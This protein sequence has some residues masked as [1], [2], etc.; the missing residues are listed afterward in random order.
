MKDKLYNLLPVALQN[1]LVSFEG[2]RRKKLRFDNDFSREISKEVLLS[3]TK[4]EQLQHVRVSEYLTKAKKESSFWAKH[5]SNDFLDGFKLEDI[6]KLPITSKQDILA[7]KEGFQSPL[8]D[9]I[10]EVKTSGTSG[11][12]LRFT[13]SNNCV[14]QGFTL[15]W[16]ECY[17]LHNHGDKYGTFNGNVITPLKQN[18]PPYWRYNKAFNQTLF[19]IFHMND[20]TLMSYYKEIKQ[21]PYRFLNGYP[22]SISMFAEF[23]LKN[24]LEPLRIEAIYTSSESLFEWQR[25]KME[26]AFSCKV[27][28]LYSNA[29]QTVFA[30][31]V[32]DGHYKV[33]KLCSYVW[34]KETDIE[35]EG[36][37][38]Y[39]VIGTNYNNH[40]FFFINYDTGD[41]VLLNDEG[42]VKR[43]LG[44]QDDVI[45]LEDGRK[46]GRLDHLFKNSEDVVEA[47]IIQQNYNQLD[48]KVKLRNPSNFESK[49]TIIDEIHKRISKTITVNF[50]IVEA[51]S[52]SPN[53][54]IRFV[55]KN[56]KTN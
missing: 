31:Q 24:D 12:G 40:A 44:R 49:K 22:S 26:K 43:V 25:Q 3:D 11:T 33:S 34:F 8:Q 15:L 18:K 17:F 37:K 46:V 36:E 41:L 42:K 45:E 47:Q 39:K 48:I 29:E 2:K 56:F 52:K 53:G 21:N 9:N 35:I 16:D 7:N 4:Q 10:S 23:I 1:W 51:I 55:V 32:E 28:D 19:S 30:N 38:A 50:E 20:S 54:K 5:I 6:Q 14:S 13:M 27:Y